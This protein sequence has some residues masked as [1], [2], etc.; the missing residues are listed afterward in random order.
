MVW[1]VGSAGSY[2]PRARWKRSRGPDRLVQ[3]SRSR[4]RSARLVG[5]DRHGRKF[6]IPATDAGRVYVGT[7]TAP[8][9]GFGCPTPAPLAASR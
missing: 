2:G 8:S 4:A 7:G 9:Y 1:E 3:L 6:T 5:A